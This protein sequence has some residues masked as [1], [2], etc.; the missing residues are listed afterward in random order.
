MPIAYTLPDFATS[1]VHTGIQRTGR[2]PVRDWTVP[3]ILLPSCRTFVRQETQTIAGRSG[4]QYEPLVYVIL[5]VLYS[6]AQNFLII[7]TKK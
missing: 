6:F 4:I 5:D 7:K 2:H 3:L 1:F